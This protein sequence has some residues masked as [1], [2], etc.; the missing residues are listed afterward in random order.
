[1]LNTAVKAAR[2]AGTII[3]RASNDL[4][5]LTI[6]RKRHND[7]VTRGRPRRRGRDHRVLKAA[8]PDHGFHAEESGK[9]R[10][11]PSTCGCIDPLDG[12]T[13]FL[14]GFPQYCVSIG[15]AAQGRAHTGG[16]LRPQSQRALHRDQGRGRVPEPS[17]PVAD[18]PA[19]LGCIAYLTLDPPNLPFNKPLH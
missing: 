8:Y 17:R 3:T 6:H 1:M 15:A 18:E 14:H 4:E 9:D 12:T 19:T 2:K 13:N 5:R 7:F 16:G 10:A 11:K